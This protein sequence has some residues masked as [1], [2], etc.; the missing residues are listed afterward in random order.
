MSGF[1]LSALAVR[2][3]A[4]TLFFLIAII[5]AGVFAFG[6]GRSCFTI[7]ALT[8]SAVWPGATAEEM[9]NL[10]AEPLEKRL[11]ELRWYDRVETFTRPGFAF[12][13]MTLQDKTPPSVVQEEFYQ[14][15]KK[16]GDEAHKLP[17]GALGPFVNDEYSNV[18]FALYAVKARGMQP[19]EV[20]GVHS[21]YGLHTRAAT[22]S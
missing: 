3:R 18:D 22:Y 13:T 1:N 4:I 20:L 7:K 10:V 5:L 6:R 9:Q 21:R 19:R 12:M 16:M 14:A 17:A 8:V 11:Q 15:R 2:E